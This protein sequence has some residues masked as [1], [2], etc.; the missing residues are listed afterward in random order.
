M[1]ARF[2]VSLYTNQLIRVRWGTCV[3]VSFPTC[4]GVKQGGV[5]SPLLFT[6]YIDE[7]LYRLSCS[8]SGCHIGAQFH[9]AYGYA[10]DVILLVPSL[11]SL[12]TL[13]NICST[14][15]LKYNVK[16]NPT[17]S[18]LIIYSPNTHESLSP[19]VEFMGG[20]IDVVTH[21][22]HLG[23]L[24]GHLSQREIV[25]SIT[26]DFLS[27]VNMVKFHFKHIPTDTMYFLF[28]TYCMPLYGSDLWDLSSNAMNVFYVAWRK[29]IRYLLNLPRTTHC[30]LLNYI[31]ND[32]PI[33]NQLCNRLI[34]L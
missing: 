30:S 14:Y 13:L 5:M 23:N 8:K 7:L 29:S 31:C 1:I 24:I 16:F 15:A 21:D 12:K 6:M 19:K 26:N 25:S 2:L 33:F 11:L 20:R 17:K 9:G 22:K 3:G 28:K 18:K 10:D 34:N 4:N 32:V 27:R